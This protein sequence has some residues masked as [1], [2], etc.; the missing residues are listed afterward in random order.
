MPAL[1]LDDVVVAPLLAVVP[2]VA[3]DIFSLLD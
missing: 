3:S 2:P 1:P